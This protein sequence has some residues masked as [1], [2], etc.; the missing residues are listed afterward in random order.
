[1]SALAEPD[2]VRAALTLWCVNKHEWSCWGDWSRSRYQAYP[3]VP[4]CPKCGEPRRACHARLDLRSL[5]EGE[6][7]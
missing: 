6:D 2:I 1:M 5:P 4:V 7:E 3:E